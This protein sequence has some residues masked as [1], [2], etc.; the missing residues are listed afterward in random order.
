M[1]YSRED[2][3]LTVRPEINSETV[4]TNIALI[5]TGVGLGFGMLKTHFATA[6]IFSILAWMGPNGVLAC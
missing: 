5:G 1:M 3:A 6:P 2:S 4:I